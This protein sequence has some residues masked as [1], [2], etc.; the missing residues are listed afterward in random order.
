MKVITV[1]EHFT[2]PEA[3]AVIQKYNASLPNQA[4]FKQYQQDMNAGMLGATPAPG[5]MTDVLDERIRYM[6][7]QGITMQVLSAAGITPQLLPAEL[8]IPAARELNEALAKNIEQKP[9][10]FIGLATLPLKDPAASVEELEYAVKELDL[11]GAL[12]SGTID[13]RFVDE[14]EFFPVFEK[15]AELDVP[16]YIHPGY[17][18][19]TE[20][21]VLY[22]SDS[23]SA[24]VK[25][26]LSTPAFGWHMEA[27]IQ[28]VRLI[29]SGI[30]D[31]LPNLKIISGHWG[32]F[33]PT[34]LN[35]IDDITDPV[36]TG[37]KKRFS[38]YYREHIYI[39]PSGIFEYDQLLFNLNRVG[40][41][42][43]MWGEDYPFVKTDQAGR[44][45]ENAP[46]SPE[47]KEKIAHETAEKLFKL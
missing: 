38:E 7:E 45:I 46:I 2:T 19:K 3:M 37:L 47:S 32:E 28:V 42:H 35:R 8:A 23:Y 17:P 13:G 4:E 44:F 25:S 43:M 9:D 21:D 1:E 36:E 22:K 20:T 14:P 26:I 41:D 5:S 27:G 24:A 18:T 34:F 10:R 31:R 16:I 29:F 11:R 33:V 30:F 39:N 15:A 6:D 40:A 12:I